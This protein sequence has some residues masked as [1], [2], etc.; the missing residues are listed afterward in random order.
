MRNYDELKELSSRK[1]YE[2]MKAI[3][4]HE[5]IIQVRE[6]I[7]TENWTYTVMELAPGIEL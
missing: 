6:F 5:T 1:E 7:A 4:Y 2:F 3:P